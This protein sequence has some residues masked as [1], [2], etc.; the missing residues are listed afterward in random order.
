MGKIKPYKQLLSYLVLK[1]E[2][3]F[4]E[5]LIS[6]L[7]MLAGKEIT[8]PGQEFSLEVMPLDSNSWSVKFDKKEIFISVK[9][10]T[11]VLSNSIL[12]LEKVP[13]STSNSL[14]SN[15]FYM[16]NTNLL[17]VENSAVLYSSDMASFSKELPEHYWT[18]I[19]NVWPD[20]KEF[21][22]HLPNYLSIVNME[23]TLVRE[24]EILKYESS[25]KANAAA[26]YFSKTSSKMI[27]D[28][29]SNENVQLDVD[30]LVEDKT[31]TIYSIINGVFE[32]FQSLINLE[33]IPVE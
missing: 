20:A 17:N 30:I 5:S 10:D 29:S 16:K 14:L 18:T 32:F 7:D 2:K 19:N 23:D 9:H 3:G 6:R 28:A 11:V 4:T 15:D 21:F 8:L 31:V 26:K 1:F 22:S 33:N 24:Y 13:F 12:T 25:D 27:Q